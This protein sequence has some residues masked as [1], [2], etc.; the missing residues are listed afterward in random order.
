MSD[1]EDDEQLELREWFS[2]IRLSDSGVKKLQTN[3]I[4]DVQTLLL[5]RECDVEQLKLGL[6]DSLRFKDGL[7]SL[8]LK[9]KTPP[10][11]ETGKPD[12]PIVSS[13]STKDLPVYTQRQ[14]EELLAGKSAV[15]AACQ[16]CS[17]PLTT[18]C[19]N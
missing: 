11:F 5:L 16:D 2:R 19:K 13:N 6:G 10:K 14:V 15:S 3:Q 7:L 18:T 4:T 1:H 17:K 9:H 8:N 12:V